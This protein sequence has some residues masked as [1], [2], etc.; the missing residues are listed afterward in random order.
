MITTRRALLTGL[1]AL[2]AAPAIVRASSLMPVKA[3][4]DDG[5]ALQSISHPL[6]C[7]V[8][9]NGAEL[10]PGWEGWHDWG[11]PFR[12][13]FRTLAEATRFIGNQPASIYLMPGAHDIT[14]VSVVKGQII[15]PC[16]SHAM[17]G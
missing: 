15:V 7:V 17:P 8:D 16:P 10:A 3:W 14:G 13:N 6:Y 1:G 9:P 11:V 4:V 5:V 2:L 12:Y